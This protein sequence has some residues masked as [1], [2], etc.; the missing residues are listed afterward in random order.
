MN[1]RTH[2]QKPAVRRAAYQHPAA[3]HRMHILAKT[4]VKSFFNLE[5]L[6]D[7]NCVI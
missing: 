3:R 6:S 2:A 4:K 7:R 1:S 5:Q